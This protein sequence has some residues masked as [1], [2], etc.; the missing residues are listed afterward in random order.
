MQD[1]QNKKPGQSQGGDD[2]SVEFEPSPALETAVSEGN[3]GQMSDQ[4][5]V[6]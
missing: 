4:A 5:Q 1:D 2:T 3:E 6:S